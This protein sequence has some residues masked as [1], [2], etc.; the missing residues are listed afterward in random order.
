MTAQDAAVTDVIRSYYRAYET[1]DRALVESL[2]SDDFTFSS[3][4]DDHI[5]RARFFAKCWPFHEQLRTFHLLQV[6]IDGDH[7]L[8]RYQAEKIDGD[9]F[10]N[11]EHLELDQ[12]RRR[13]S[14]ID[15]YFGALPG[16][17]DDAPS[18]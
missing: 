11:V 8:V 5:D 16:T 18:S 17:D 12:A 14:H 4:R 2:L 1:S 9:G 10:C 13:I 15:V 7:A 6:G 3:P